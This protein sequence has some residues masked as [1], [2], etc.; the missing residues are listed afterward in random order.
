MHILENLNRRSLTA[1]Y[2]GNKGTE[3]NTIQMQVHPSQRIQGNGTRLAS[4]VLLFL[5][6][7]PDHARSPPPA[8][9]RRRPLRTTARR[10]RPSCVLRQRPD[11]SAVKSPYGRCQSCSE[12]ASGVVLTSQQEI[13]VIVEGGAVHPFRRVRQACA[14]NEDFSIVSS[15]WSNR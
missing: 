6:R 12:L 2:R 13:C 10:G 5:D 14:G 11:R 9:S 3:Q 15:P 1:A 7:L 4:R 8:S